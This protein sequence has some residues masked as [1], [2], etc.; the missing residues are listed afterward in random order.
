MLQLGSQG[1]VVVDLAVE[2]D[3]VRVV[4]VGHRLG[5]VGES[6]DCEPSM[7]ERNADRFSGA[8]GVD[9]A[10]PNAF[11]VRPS[12]SEQG[13]HSRERHVIDR[14]PRIG[15]N[16]ARDSAHK[17]ISTVDLKTG[18]RWQIEGSD[19]SSFHKLQ[20]WAKE[21]NRE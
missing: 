18:L 4:L 6:D 14:K 12:M 13:G 9:V 20:R 11:R 15:P 2:N 19:I 16:G 10:T 5:S 8:R 17:M 7:P 21:V 3:R 1:Q